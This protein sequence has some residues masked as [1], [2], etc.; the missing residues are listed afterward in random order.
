MLWG[1]RAFDIRFQLLRV[2]L[3][4]LF[5]RG[6][7]LPNLK[8][9]NMNKQLCGSKLLCETSATSGKTK[10]AFRVEKSSLRASYILLWTVCGLPE[11]PRFTNHDAGETIQVIMMTQTD[12]TVGETSRSRNVPKFPRSKRDTSRHC[13]ICS[14]IALVLHWERHGHK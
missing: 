13:L 10:I 14:C 6:K 12:A 4:F 7:P 1:T 9:L 3:W 11:F 2:L 8:Y 5:N